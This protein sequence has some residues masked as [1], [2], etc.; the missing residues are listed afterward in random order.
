MLSRAIGRLAPPRPMTAGE[1][2]ARTVR[3]ILV[4]R[5]HHEIGDLLLATPLFAALRRGFPGAAVDLL[6][7]R[8]AARAVEGNPDLAEVLVLD[9]KALWNP[10]TLRR[11][12][13][14]L[15]GVGY[16]LAVVSSTNTSSF[17]NGLLARLTGAPVVGFETRPQGARW[18]EDLYH[19]LVPWRGDGRPQWDVNLDLARALDCPVDDPRL[20]FRVEPEARDWARG[21]LGE[22]APDGRCVGV[23]IGGDVSRSDRLWDAENAAEVVRAIGGRWRAVLIGAPGPEECLVREVAR[24]L[25]DGRVP[26]AVTPAFGRLAGLLSELDALV[27]TDGAVL[28]LAAA[29]GCSVTGIFFGTDPAVWAPPGLRVSALRGNDG[30]VEV[31]AVVEGVRRAGSSTW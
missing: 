19:L 23:F 8:Y 9:R 25:G 12:W 22:H 6:V 26:V 30:K 21:W 20:V 10:A 14:R 3:R 31:D 16:D 2:R 11:W 29:V 13:R 24:R 15:R 27:T 7:N 18:G 17:M 5:Q 4:V 1:I 28:Q